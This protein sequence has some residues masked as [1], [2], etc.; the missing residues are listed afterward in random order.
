MNH[1][2][3]GAAFTL[4][5][6]LAM[7]GG[8]VADACADEHTIDSAVT[9]SPKPLAD[10]QPASTTQPQANPDA[11]PADAPPADKQPKP[12]EA[13]ADAVTKIRDLDWKI[14]IKPRAWYVSPAGKLQMPGSTNNP[15]LDDINADSP[16]LAP[17]GEV[18]MKFDAWRIALGGFTYSMK[19]LFNP[20][21]SGQLGTI[22]YNNGDQIRTKLDFTSGQILGG[23]RIGRWLLNPGKDGRL[24]FVPELTGLAGLRIHQADF[25][26]TKIGGAS[27][28]SNRTYAEAL[29]GARLDMDL[30][31]RWS[32]NVHTL[33][34]DQPFGNTTAFS[35][36]IA[37]E[38]EWRPTPNIG[39]QAGYRN[40]FLDLK[41]GSGAQK[42]EWDGGFA[43]LFFGLNLRF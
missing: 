23:Y 34:G 37:V 42:F 18:D 26:I 39:L 7:C 40:L 27:E 41:H 31:Q 28:E 30:S 14:S 9:Y 22:A 10:D 13:A 36:D 43:G 38:L 15:R 20:T 5:G 16:R 24:E 33:F 35:W 3:R 8:S 32:I 19:P 17:Y 4:I 11:P 21:G 1:E 29:V 25:T 2:R 12:E 6:V